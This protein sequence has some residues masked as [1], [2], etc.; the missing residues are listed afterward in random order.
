MTILD[1]GGGYPGYHG[2]SLDQIAAIINTNLDLHFPEGCG[3]DVIAEPGRYYVTSAFTLA[4][5]IHGRKKCGSSINSSQE[6]SYFYYINDGAYGSFLQYFSDR[7]RA[8]APKLLNSHSGP[9]FKSTIWGP[10]C[11]SVDCVLADCSLPVLD[12][13]DWLIFENMGDYTVSLAGTFNGFPIPEVYPFVQTETWSY[14]KKKLPL[15]EDRFEAD[16]SKAQCLQY[17]LASH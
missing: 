4:T 15:T 1:L 6:T 5:C 14:L 13:G 12:V 2:S 10:S 16:G 8:P 17:L 7:I 3:V 11:A 9:H